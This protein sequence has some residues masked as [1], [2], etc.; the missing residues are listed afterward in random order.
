MGSAF[1]QLP[2]VFALE[3]QQE[4]KS[5]PY[6]QIAAL[7]EFFAARICLFFWNNC[8]IAWNKGMK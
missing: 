5:C 7:F 6:S 8:L 2:A 3:V 4:P 1:A